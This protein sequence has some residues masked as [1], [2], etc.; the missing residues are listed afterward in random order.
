MEVC[1]VVFLQLSLLQA[2]QAQ[3]P[4]PVFVGEVL[5][6]PFDRSEIIYAIPVNT[7]LI[8]K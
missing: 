7:F 4:Q 6:K 3:L 2:E 8:P 5:Q 1:N